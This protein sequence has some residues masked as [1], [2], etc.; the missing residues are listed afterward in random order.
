MKN[1]YHKKA[2]KQY[3]IILLTLFGAKTPLVAFVGEI[4][5]GHSDIVFAGLP[6]LC[7]S[8]WAIITQCTFCIIVSV[9]MAMVLAMFVVEKNWKRLFYKWWLCQ[10]NG[11][12]DVCGGKKMHS[13]C[14]NIDH[15]DSDGK[16]I[17]ECTMHISKCWRCQASLQR[18]STPSINPYSELTTFKPGC[19]LEILPFGISTGW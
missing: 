1:T 6:W 3:S 2:L 13:D 17:T 10:W 19:I 5:R 14:F 15:V 7:K 4:F 12:E 16:I 11:V 8:L 9:L 18:R